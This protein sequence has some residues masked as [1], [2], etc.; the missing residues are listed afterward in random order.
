MGDGN[1]SHLFCLL[2]TIQL[3]VYVLTMLGHAPA[4]VSL[5]WKTMALSDPEMAMKLRMED[6]DLVYGIWQKCHGT[7]LDGSCEKIEGRQ[8]SCRQKRIFIFDHVKM[9]T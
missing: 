7:L 4:M 1:F 5:G 6:K 2:A 9:T 3:A 8:L